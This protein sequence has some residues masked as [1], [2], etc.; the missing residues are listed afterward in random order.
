MSSLLGKQLLRSSV[1]V[2]AFPSSTYRGSPSLVRHLSAKAPSTFLLPSN[3]I[4]SSLKPVSHPLDPTAHRLT[5]SLG[6]AVGLT[7]QGI[8]LTRIPTG[9]TRST[10]PHWHSAEEEWFYILEGKGYAVIIDDTEGTQREVEVE[11][12]DFLGFPGGF[13][14]RRFAHAFRS[15]KE[16]ELVYLCGG[17]RV[18][19]DAVHYPD[20]DKVL[21]IHRRDGKTQG[22]LVGD[23][24]L[25]PMS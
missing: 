9:E 21:L 25:K 12:G 16:G 4:S 3:T 8:H 11:K 20:K 19:T 18:D 17:T 5:V 2:A 14:A 6:D 22:I 10:I 23:A 7:Q 24:N 1:R 15:S 13:E